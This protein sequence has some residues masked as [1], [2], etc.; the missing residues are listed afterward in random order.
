MH[1]GGNQKGR[2]GKRNP[3]DLKQ[4]FLEED[5]PE[6]YNIYGKAVVRKSRDTVEFNEEAR[7]YVETRV[8]V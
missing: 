3:K 2:G 6:H 8:I 4:P 7:L 5:K 1:K